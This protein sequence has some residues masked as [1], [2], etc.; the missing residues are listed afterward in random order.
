VLR[1]DY[2]DPT[3]GLGGAPPA[4]SALG[5]RL[6]LAVFG[7]TVCAA[8]TVAFALA[9]YGAVAAAAGVLAAIGVVDIIVIRRRQAVER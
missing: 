7:V 5:L 2:H 6:V 9:G 1:E 3:A 8:A 4:R